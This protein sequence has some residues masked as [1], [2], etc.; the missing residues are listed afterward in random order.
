MKKRFVLFYQ[1]NLRKK[2]FLALKKMLQRNK[3]SPNEEKILNKKAI[4][5]R[6]HFIFKGYF[7]FWKFWIFS[8]LKLKKLSHKN[9]FSLRRKTL[10]KTLFFFLKKN[11][12]VINF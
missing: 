9:A 8:A 4:Q 5:F 1:K 7:K 12:E 11:V 2:V 10:L 3:L 6:K